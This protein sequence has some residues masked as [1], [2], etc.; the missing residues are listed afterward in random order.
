MK[1]YVKKKRYRMHCREQTLS[2]LV[3][4]ASGAW[5][6]SGPNMT[7]SVKNNVLYGYIGAEP[8]VGRPRKG[9]EV[10][11]HI[12]IYRARFGGSN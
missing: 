4:Q 1:S 10:R 8:G 5:S 2:G 12:E 6:T 3:N 9:G 7:D 11:S